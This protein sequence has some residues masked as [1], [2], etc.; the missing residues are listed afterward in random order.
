MSDYVVVFITACSPEEGERLA[1]ALVKEML[2][3]CVNVLPALTSI[4]CWEGEIRRDTETLLIVKSH[5]SVLDYLVKRVKNLHRYELPEI[6][7]LPIVGGLEDYLQWIG[8]A[9]QHGWHN[10]E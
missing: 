7:A 4:Y 2:A 9:V 1:E 5:K 10:I 8:R 6:I 3:A